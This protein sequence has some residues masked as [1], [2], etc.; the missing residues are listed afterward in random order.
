MSLARTQRVLSSALF[1]SF[2]TVPAGAAQ[3]VSGSGPLS[4]VDRQSLVLVLLLCAGWIVVRFVLRQIQSASNAPNVSRAPR[5]DSLRKRA[6]D[7]GSRSDTRLDADKP[8]NRALAAHVQGAN[9]SVERDERR[10]HRAAQAPSSAGPTPTGGQPPRVMPG[11]GRVSGPAAAAAEPRG[12]ESGAISG[13]VLDAMQCRL[14]D[15]YIAVRFPGVARSS[16]DL[17]TS[18]AIIKAARLYFEDATP[19]LAIELLHMAIEQH[20]ETEALWLA[21]IETLFLLRLP[22]EFCRVA[23]RFRNRHPES[24]KWPEVARLGMLIA[25]DSLLFRGAA[26]GPRAHEHY[27]PWPDLPN[28]IQAPWDLTPEL[29]A[30]EFHARMR[31]Q[32]NALR[33]ESAGR[34]LAA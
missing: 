8:M 10:P 13:L 29:R 18:S 16:Q 1:A 12:S 30:A 5:K 4:G 9:G 34:A 26:A 32:L 31:S 14:R 25:G 7:P 2:V 20:P 19:R 24:A 15:R 23:A 6:R 11:T 22:N 21:L 17:E 3:S 27:G 33:A 28:W